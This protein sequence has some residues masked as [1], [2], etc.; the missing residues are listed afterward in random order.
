MGESA[1]IIPINTTRFGLAEHSYQR[2]S[3]RVA[4]GTT[5]KELEAPEF[6][7]HVRSKLRTFDEIR[8]VWDDGSA[9]AT[10]LVA[11]GD[12]QAIYCKVIAMAE[13]D[14]VDVEELQNQQQRFECRQKGVLKWTIVDNQDG[15]IIKQDMP[16]RAIAE[17]E[18]E[19]Y[20][21]A[22]AR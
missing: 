5:K 6:W 18:L 12:R 3:A 14:Q 10:L 22:Q 13:L 16:S 17:R 19:E 4:A 2:F 11:F 7:A 15:S 8:V 9:V 1:T 21:R 20:L